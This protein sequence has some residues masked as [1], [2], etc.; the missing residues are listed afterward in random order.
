M[1]RRK[2]NPF[3][4]ISSGL[5]IYN[6]I[7]KLPGHTLLGLFL[8]TMKILFYY[9]KFQNSS[10]FT[11]FKNATIELKKVALIEGKFSFKDLLWANIFLSSKGS[12]ICFF[13]LNKFLINFILPFSFSSLSNTC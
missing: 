10:T 2:Q 13:H 12:K 9:V 4:K 7:T 11:P 6:R 3:Q 8:V 5:T 1:K